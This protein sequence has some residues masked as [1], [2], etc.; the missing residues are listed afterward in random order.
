MRAAVDGGAGRPSARRLG[1]L[2]ITVTGGAGPLGT[3]RGDARPTLRRRARRRRPLAATHRLATVPWARNERA[4]VAGL[5]TT[6]YA[7]NVVAARAA[8]PS[9]APPRR[10]SPTRVGELCEGTGS[11]VFVVVERRVCT[12]PLSSGCLAGMTRASW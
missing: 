6:S 1:R 2:R 8:P 9:A 3:D 10:S 5:K 11:N 7:E 12:P 4:A